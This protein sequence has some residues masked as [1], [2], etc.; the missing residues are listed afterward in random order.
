MTLVQ[1][2]TAAN[3]PWLSV[4]DDDGVAVNDAVDLAMTSYQRW[5]LSTLLPTLDSGTAVD[6]LPLTTRLHNQLRRRELDDFGAI[7][8]LTIADLMSW[9]ALSERSVRDSLIG[10][11]STIE[12]ENSVPTVEIPISIAEDGER[13]PAWHGE[14]I[15]DI[16]TLARW[17]RMLGADDI[18][19]LGEVE[20]IVEPEHVRAAR[21]RFARLTARDVIP[22]GRSSIAVDII[23]LALSTLEERQLAIARDR[24]FADEPKTL[25]DLGADFEVTRERIRQLET[26]AK[27]ALDAQL[28]AGDFAALADAVRGAIGSVIPLRSLL[29][30]YPSLA[31]VAPSV[32]QP[33][34]RVLD[35]LDDAY[36]IV[37]GWCIRGKLASAAAETK[38]MLAEKAESRGYVE[39]DAL[40]A[41]DEF[42]FDADW[43][44]H[45]GVTVFLGF[46]VTG[47]ASIPDRAAIVLE[48]SGEPLGAEDILAKLGADRS[49]TSLKNALSVDPRLARVDRDR[50]ALT[51]WGLEGYQS[52]RK[53]I[54]REI[55]EAGGEIGLDELIETLTSKFEISASSIMTYSAAHPYELERGTVRWLEVGKQRQRR[56]GILQTR[57]LFRHPRATLF[58]IEV[59][60]EHLRGSGAPLPNAI[61][62]ALDL[63]RGEASELP[64]RGGGTI[65]VSWRGPQITLG[66]TRS[67]LEALGAEPG[68]IAFLVFHDD[69]TFEVTKAGETSS[70]WA[71]LGAL[72]GGELPS[73]RNPL[74][75]LAMRIDSPARTQAELLAEFEKRG[76]TAVAA[77]LAG[78]VAPTTQG[79]A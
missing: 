5:P 77:I 41:E 65:L 31:A 49:L 79:S 2:V 75:P 50:W 72:T 55:D 16:E 33:V 8:D 35:R 66:S 53:M 47:R 74:R 54:G 4:S 40:L 63:T 46:A 48:H 44:E 24:L 18:S 22:D 39:L 59:N 58:R 6:A 28:G 71:R 36:E 17:H 73:S 13:A 3:F 38:R 19:V 11:L 67:L 62:E 45:I 29:Q 10:V 30:R 68:D 32:D 56:K 51:E 34:W 76:D 20:G 23:E 12:T 9:D 78:E 37:D 21:A 57:S 70:D 60:G 15:A 42:L 64:V 43:L 69:D 26:K 14:L 1:N 27:Q 7:G 25:D 61:G 52:I